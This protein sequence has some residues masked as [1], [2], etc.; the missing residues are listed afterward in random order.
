MHCFLSP[1]LPFSTIVLDF[2]SVDFDISLLVGDKFFYSNDSGTVN[3]L[4]GLD[5]TFQ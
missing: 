2:I 3:W 5:R 1:L 4:L